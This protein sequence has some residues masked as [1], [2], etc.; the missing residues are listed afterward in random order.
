MKESAFQIVLVALIVTGFI[1]IFVR[2]QRA[3]MQTR[4]STPLLPQVP[5]TF[6]RIVLDNLRTGT[7]FP[8]YDAFQKEMREAYDD[9]YGH[10]GPYLGMSKIQERASHDL[11]I[12]LR[13]FRE[14]L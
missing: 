5:K 11:Y 7:T 1:I 4:T 6:S 9:I 3:K 8:S 12:A 13:G 2:L 10:D 14:T